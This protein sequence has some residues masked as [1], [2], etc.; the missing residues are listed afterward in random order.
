MGSSRNAQLYF[1]IG[2][3]LPH[4]HPEL[5]KNGTGCAY[6]RYFKDIMEGLAVGL[7]NKTPKLQKVVLPVSGCIKVSG[8]AKLHF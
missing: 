3:F 8:N 6:T 2:S 7:D 1:Y 4:L 5:F